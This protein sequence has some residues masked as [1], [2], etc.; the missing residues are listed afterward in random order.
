MKLPTM[1][2]ILYGKSKRLLWNLVKILLLYLCFAG[3]Y[4]LI[5]EVFDWAKEGKSMIKK[6]IK[7]LKKETEKKEAPEMRERSRTVEETGRT[8]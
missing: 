4:M 7:K 3:S 8:A 1:I 5:S 6:E 2:G